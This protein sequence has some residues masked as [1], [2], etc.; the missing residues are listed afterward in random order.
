MDSYEDSKIDKKIDKVN[1][2]YCRHYYIT[3]DA[4][5]PNGCRL[6]AFESKMMPHMMVKKESGEE[7]LA[8]EPKK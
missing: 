7:C 4:L 8:F 6:H 2:R 1:C 3:Y 5:T